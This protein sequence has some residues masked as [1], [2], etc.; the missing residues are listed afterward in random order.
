M[1]TEVREYRCDYCGLK[2]FYSEES[3]TIH[4]ESCISN[5]KVAEEWE[6][7]GSCQGTGNHYGK[8]RQGVIGYATC[9][10]CGGSGRRKKLK[11]PQE[12]LDELGKKLD[13]A[14]SQPSSATIKKGGV[15]IKPE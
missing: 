4:E 9:R 12:V 14:L 3:A 1:P 11:I 8:Q 10:S 2:G 5:P 13:E 7:C 15:K 6:K